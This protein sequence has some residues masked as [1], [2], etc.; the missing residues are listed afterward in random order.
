MTT[1]E[2]DGHFSEVAE[3]LIERYNRGKPE[4]ENLI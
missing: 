1:I 3:D 2:L 4:A